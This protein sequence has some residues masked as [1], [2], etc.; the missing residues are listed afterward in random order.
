MAEA[1]RQGRARAVR[2]LGLLCGACVGLAIATAARAVPLF[3]ADYLS[4][5]TGGRP[6][7]AAAADLNRDG[8]QDLV[9]ANQATGTITVLLGLGDGTVSRAGDLPVGNSPISVALGDLDGDGNP[10][11]VIAD[12]ARDQVYVLRGLGNGGFDTTRTAIPT[13][14]APFDVVLSD[15]DGDGHLDAV[16]ANERGNSSSTA[17]P[18]PTRSRWR[19]AT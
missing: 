19:S 16:V 11:A 1:A 18:S 10:D 3:A 14:K 8:H 9:V 5:D 15:I 2:V 4:F 13:G 6:W 17:T 12:L 7:T